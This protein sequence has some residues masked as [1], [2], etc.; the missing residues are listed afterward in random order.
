[1]TQLTSRLAS[2]SLS[3][4][5]N[6]QFSALFDTCCERFRNDDKDFEAWYSKDDLKLL[7]SIGYQHREFF[8]FV[9][10]Y[11]DREDPSPGTALLIAAVRRDYF[12]VIQNREWSD[13]PR[14]MR[15]EIPEFEEE[16]EGIRYLPRILKKARGKLRGELDPDLMFGCGGDRR[17]LRENGDIHPA[18]FLRVVWAHDDDDAR[19][20]D[21]VRAQ[22]EDA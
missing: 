21:W 8:D 2:P 18:D 19:I 4:T 15:D 1:M 6:D 3:M 11:C 7:D 5:W 16:F 10:D 14:V 12:I 20:A 9:E 22:K 17:F 13:A